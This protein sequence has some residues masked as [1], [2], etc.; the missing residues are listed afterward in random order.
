MEKP[1]NCWQCGACCRLVRLLPEIAHLDRGDGACRHLQEDLKCGIYEN[2]PDACNTRVTYE[3]KWRE[4]WSWDEYLEQAEEACH[5]LDD[6][7]NGG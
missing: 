2:R 5:L 3:A 1:F 7:V 6:F 4:R